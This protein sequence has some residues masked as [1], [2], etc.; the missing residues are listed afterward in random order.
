MTRPAFSAARIRED[1]KLLDGKR[2]LA[3]GALCCERLLPNYLAF[4][5]DA[6]WGDFASVRESLNYVW[7]YIFGEI[8]VLDEIAG[9][10]SSCEL[11]APSSDKFTSLYVTAAQD[12]CF[13]VCSL[14]DCIVDE[15]VGKIVQVATYATDSID[16][17][18]QETDR[19]DPNDPDLEMKILAHPLM[20]RELERQESDIAALRGAEDISRDFLDHRKMSNGDGEIGNLSL[21]G[22]VNKTV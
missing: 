11:A 15:D 6:G 3:F 20:Q 16:L 18:I 13:S 14:L 8:K 10:I 4:E 7:R 1:L 22:P 19:I 9:A 17:F 21:S 5:K 2:R 12:A